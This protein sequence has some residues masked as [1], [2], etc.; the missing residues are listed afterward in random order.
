MKCVSCEYGGKH[1]LGTA[2]G[3]K[4][5]C[6]AHALDSEDLRMSMMALITAE[7]HNEYGLLKT[8]IQDLGFGNLQGVTLLMVKYV[9]WMMR[10]A[11][12]DPVKTVQ[13]AALY[14]S[15]GEPDED[16]LD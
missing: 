16:Q 1:C 11:D 3:C 9:V 6:A 8:L 12:L 13:E 14:W 10:T 4:C 7:A 15:G 2:P 5:E